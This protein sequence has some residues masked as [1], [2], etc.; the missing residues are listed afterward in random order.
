MILLA[1][2]LL[3]MHLLWLLHAF[4]PMIQC[5]TGLTNIHFCPHH[6][7]RQTLVNLKDRIPLQQR[8]SVVYRVPCGTCPKVYVGQTCRT[9]DHRLKEHRRALTSGNLAQSAIA[10]HAA[11][12]SHVID[13]KE[14]K[15]VDTHPRY[16]Q[17]CALESWHIRS[18]TNTM[19]RDDG[20][21]PQ[22]Y[23]SLLNYP[24]T[25]H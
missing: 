5:P 21:L 10:E 7:L 15:V 19:N 25:S 2:P 18:E 11:Q 4:E 9:L 24:H 1:R 8:A 12:E 14:A 17:R 22:A 20:N 16:H 3:F 6:T 23:N 13:W